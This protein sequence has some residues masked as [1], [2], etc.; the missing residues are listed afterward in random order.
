MEA[1][2][3]DVVDLYDDGNGGVR[4]GFTNVASNLPGYM[5]YLDLIREPQ[6]A[7][8]LS[9]LPPNTVETH[10]EMVPE[11]YKETDNREQRKAESCY[12]CNDE[13]FRLSVLEKR[14]QKE[15][16]HE[17]AKT[18]DT[19][20]PDDDSYPENDEDAS[21]ALGAT[22]MQDSTN[23]DVEEEEFMADVIGGLAQDHDQ[24]DVGMQGAIAESLKE[25]ATEL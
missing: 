22:D 19:D 10:I 15:A 20:T 17:A 16:A 11:M 14:K 2:A 25:L 7:F 8:G 3:E 5:Q 23:V 9:V 21:P 24:D 6:L 18:S 4:S 1:L 12:A 13:G